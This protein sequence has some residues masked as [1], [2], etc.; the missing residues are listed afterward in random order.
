MR[1][2]RV[3]VGGR[4]E[5]RPGR[6]RGKQRARPTFD[7]A[8][9][10]LNL[11]SPSVPFTLFNTTIAT[12]TDRVRAPL[13]WVLIGS[14]GCGDSAHIHIGRPWSA[15]A[16]SDASAVL[17]V[18]RHGIFH[19]P[20]AA[21]H[22]EAV[23][24]LSTSPPPVVRRRPKYSSRDSLRSLPSRPPFFRLVTRFINRHPCIF[25]PPYI[26]RS[27][28]SSLFRQP[29][30]CFFLLG[31]VYGN[32][33]PPNAGATKNALRS[34]VSST[35]LWTRSYSA[36]TV[37]GAV[38]SRTCDFIMANVP[39]ETTSRATVQLLNPGPDE[40]WE[41]VVC[42]ENHFGG[43]AL[44][45]G[46]EYPACKSLSCCCEGAFTEYTMSRRLRCAGTVSTRY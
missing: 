9:S 38:S 11:I 45:I 4:F 27:L 1:D 31:W 36:Y 21:L 14:R 23:N 5:S 13:K 15:C 8:K 10:Q 6:G 20:P 25:P 46:A 32:V 39:P 40:A 24:L 22:M 34:L 42:D 19:D 33:P 3:Q 44:Q 12:T 7:T 18:F 17:F 41:C 28:G 35:T 29:R 26:S 2:E 16:P 43:I 37:H 30:S